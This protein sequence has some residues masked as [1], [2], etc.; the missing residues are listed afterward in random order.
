MPGKCAATRHL[1]PEPNYSCRG[2]KILPAKGNNGYTGVRVG[3]E[4]SHFLTTAEKIPETHNHGIE[5]YRTAFQTAAAASYGR[6]NQGPHAEK[7][8]LSAFSDL[9]SSDRGTLRTEYS[10]SA[11]RASPRPETFRSGSLNREPARLTAYL[12]G[13]RRSISLRIS[14]AHRTASAM[15]LMVAGTRFPPSYWHSFRAARIAAA[16]SKTRFRPS[17]TDGILSAFAIYSL[18]EAWDAASIPVNA[19]N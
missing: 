17:S 3:P 5:Q 2:G 1:W 8:T 10:C 9:W 12:E 15:A 7:G 16:I 19:G 14:S 18:L 6:E 11:H 4:T 13:Q